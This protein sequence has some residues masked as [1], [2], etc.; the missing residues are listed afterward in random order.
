MKNKTILW[1]FFSALLLTGCGTSQISTEK[2]AAKYYNLYLEGKTE[3]INNL[4]L[5][6]LDTEGTPPT[7]RK[8]ALRYMVRSG[9]AQA[10]A[11][12]LK[13][14]SDQKVP[15][16]DILQ[17]LS[18]EIA[19][20]KAV[21]WTPLALKMYK[22]Y[23]DQ[24]FQ[25]QNSMLGAIYESSGAAQITQMIE[26]YEYTRS[27]LNV[28]DENISR[29][30]GKFDDQAV[31]PL[32]INIVND[33]KKNIRVRETAL[34]LL[35]EK[36][37]PRI[38]DV[39]TKLLGDPK[40][41]LMIRDFAFNVLETGSD[42]KILLALLEFLQRNKAKENKMMAAITEALGNYGNP[43]I[44][45]SLQFIYENLSFP[46][47]LREE[48]LSALIKFDNRDVLEFLIIKTY[49]TGQYYFCE[50]VSDAVSKSGNRE[51]R[52]MMEIAALQDQMKRSGGQK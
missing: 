15:E 30:L 5:A 2:E 29:L 34:L 33:P 7:V 40:Q 10:R 27:N 14:A 3:A 6:F 45:P 12:L 21:S 39:L 18:D 28:V 16:P 20:Q 9:D 43:A 25:L 44:I 49:E 37:D 41:E 42:E 47:Q 52:Q 50:A 35:S 36:N 17:T 1:I 4:S 32:L 23:M 19:A 48:A 38:A 31:I 51:L 46:Y 13:Y 8:A 11:A 24:S 26:V 22:A